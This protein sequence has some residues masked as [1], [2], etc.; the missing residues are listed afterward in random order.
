LFSFYFIFEEN[1]LDG[2]FFQWIFLF[3]YLCG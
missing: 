3:F 2:N 1:D